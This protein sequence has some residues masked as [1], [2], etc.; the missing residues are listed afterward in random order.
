M[1]DYAH[2]AEHRFFLARVP[3]LFGAVHLELHD[4]ERAL[5]L[6]L[7][8]EEA[9]RRFNPW[10]EPLAH[11]LLK[12]GLVHLERGDYDL[13]EKFFL[14]AWDLL[15]GD[16]LTRWRWHIPLLRARGELALA[17]GHH[18]EAWSF[19]HQSLDLATKCIARKHVAR[20]QRLQGEVLVATGKIPDAASV[21]EGSLTLAAE[22]KAAPDL[23]QC[24]LALGKVLLKL[25]RESEAESQLNMAASV[26]DGIAQ[27]LTTPN[28]RRSFLLARPVLDVYAL[29]HRP[30]PQLG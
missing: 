16:E 14:R 25:G 26:V 18:D 5:T 13:A 20:A 12:V 2:S 27:N 1:R 17:R 7:E 19:A 4:L 3:N 28:L 15:Q 10:P 22:L 6:N 8:G 24:G 30:P 11:S 23:W 29:L 9:A 21:L